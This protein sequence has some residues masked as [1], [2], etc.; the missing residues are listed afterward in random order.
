MVKFTSI[1]IKTYLSQSYDQMMTD[2][3][4]KW[5]LLQ[6]GNQCL[7]GDKFDILQQ[8]ENC[9]NGGARRCAGAKDTWCGGGNA[10]MIYRGLIYTFFS[11]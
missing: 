1:S 4:R 3:Y 11:F 10:T 2:Y 5:C 9:Y 8:S 6:F 7:C